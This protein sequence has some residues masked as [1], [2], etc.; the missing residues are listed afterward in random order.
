[1]ERFKAQ[2]VFDWAKVESG[3]ARRVLEVA[4]LALSQLL[5][6]E[7]NVR[8]LNPLFVNNSL[9]RQE[10]FLR[11]TLATHPGLEMLRAKQE[12]AKGLIQVEKGLYFP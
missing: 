2:A 10:E 1:M 5:H 7:E 6:L 11:Q 3:K 4:Q 12:Q 9:P 8:P